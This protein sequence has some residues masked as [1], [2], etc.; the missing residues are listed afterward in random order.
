MFRN[1]DDNQEKLFMNENIIDRLEAS[2]FESDPAEQ[3]FLDF[4]VFDQDEDIIKND[5]L[6]SDVNN[7][8][9]KKSIRWKMKQLNILKHLQIL[10]K[11][12]KGRRRCD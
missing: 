10:H 7:D 8:L 3:C 6:Q 1:G 11:R 12:R 5:H 2:Y 9:I 4:E